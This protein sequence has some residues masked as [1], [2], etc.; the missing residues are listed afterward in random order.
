MT[1]PNQQKTELLVGIFVFFGLALLGGLVLKFGDFRYGL[2]SKYTLSVIYRDAGNL[3]AGAP[4]RRGGVEIGRVSKDP[5]LVNGLTGVSVDLV[6]FQEYHIAKGSAFSVKTDGIIGDAFIEVTP[7]LMPTGQMLAVGDTIEGTSGADIS[8]TAT[9]VAD[10]SL[11]VL[12][13]IRGSLA[14][15][16]GAI[17]KISTGVLGDENL[18]NLGSSL[19]SLNETINKIDEQVLSTEN[20]EALNG[21]LKSLHQS[22]DKLSGNLDQLTATLSSVDDMLKR[23]VAPA[24]DEFGK[25]ATTIRKAA[26]GLGIVASD[27]HSGQGMISGLLRDPKMREDFASLISNMRRHGVFWYKD[28]A[29]KERDAPP[30]SNPRPSIF[31]R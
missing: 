14:D 3:T 23:K 19:K 1:P 30:N 31:K 16:K 20:T 17:G 18:N 9:R 15:L 22:S 8:A 21:T 26:E 13:D 25:A 12:E 28:D 11:L 27:I 29:A 5:G 4:V 10:K 24:L 7:P 2:R 6:I